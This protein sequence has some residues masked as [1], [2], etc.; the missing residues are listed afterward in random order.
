MPKLELRNIEKAFENKNISLSED[1]FK[2]S[3]I[4]LTIGDGEFLSVLGPSGC[5]KTTLLRIIS[6]L[7][8]P[9]KGRIFE[10]EI[11]ITDLPI[12]KRNFAFV[13]QQPLLFPN[14]TILENVSFGLKMQGIPKKQRTAAAMDMLY[15]LSIQGLEKRYPLQLSGGQSQRASIARAFLSNP[16]VLLMDEPFTALNEELRD[17]MKNLLLAL[18][19]KNKL[20]TI[21]VTHDKVEAQFLSDKIINMKNGKI[22]KG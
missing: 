16:K 14:M 20:T 17:E 4:N 18:H 13:S 8:I 7:A 3:D 2:L 9:D 15:N 22:L 6:G 12:E 21:F 5:G 10:N 19:R 1:N 11:D